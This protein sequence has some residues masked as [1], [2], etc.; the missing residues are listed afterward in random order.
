MAG[1]RMRIGLVGTGAVARVHMQAYRGSSAIE[2]VA[3]ADIDSGRRAAFGE[4]HRIRIYAD[5]AAML[6]SEQLDVVCVLTPPASHAAVVKACADAGIAVLCEKPLALDA[7]SAREMA[8]YCAR[9]NVRLGYGASYRFLP[10]LLR[11]RTLIAEGA[12]GAVRLLTE[13]EI[14][15]S[16]VAGQEALGFAHYPAG[17]PGG[18]SMGLVDHGIHLIDAFAW[19]ANSPIISAFGHGNI[20][21]EG[22]SVEHALL[23]LASG[24]T[25][26]LTYFDGTFSS[27][28][29]NEGLFSEGEGWTASG[30]TQAGTW[31]AQPSSIS[32]YGTTGALR[33]FHY[34]NALFLSNADGVR[35]VP[36][37]GRA[38]PYHFLTQLEAFAAALKQGAPIPAPPEPGIEA[39]RVLDAIYESR[40]SARAVRL[41]H[42][43]L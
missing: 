29:P 17:G 41:S 14:G 30:Y 18:G 13:S 24:A 22:L 31:T 9:K 35:R 33:I 37:E 20:S 7:A 12:I 25:A 19:L 40:A 1:A 42:A 38:A 43:G 21:G 10:A 11:A 16:G 2:I 28:L 23:R 36:L 3:A 27:L 39:L 34:A 6:V 32:I 4:A 26:Q 15:G 8:A 5:T